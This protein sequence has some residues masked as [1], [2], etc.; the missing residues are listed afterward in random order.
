MKAVLVKSCLGLLV[1]LELE[2]LSM[3]R[4]LGGQDSATTTMTP[5]LQ[6]DTGAGTVPRSPYP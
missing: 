3:A 1:S 2:L 6:T 5:T 4:A